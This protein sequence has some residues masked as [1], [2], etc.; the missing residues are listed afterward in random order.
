[1]WR[2]P[3][4]ARY[5]P[6][7]AIEV[8]DVAEGLAPDNDDVLGAL[9]RAHRLAGHAAL[10]ITYLERAVSIA[11]TR[12]RRLSL[13]RARLSHQHHVETRWSN[14]QFSGATPDSRSGDLI[15]NLRLTDRWRVLAR[16]QVQRKFA[17]SEERGGGGVEWRW[18]LAT[19]LRAQAL[20]GP[21]NTVMPE[22]DYLGEVE[23]TY[24]AATWTASV[25]YFDFR[26]ASTTVFSPAVAWVPEGPLS[27]ALRYAVSLT[28]T[29]TA[30][31]V[32]TGHSA[33]LRGAYRVYSWLSIQAGYAAGV[34]DFENVSIDRIGIFRA[35]T[36][37]G[38]LRIYLPTMTAVVA[39]YEHQWQRRNRNLGRVTVSLLQNF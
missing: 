10:A 4:L 21:D 13:E 36:A 6:A 5:E 31:S 37:S 1:M 29:P 11:P 28:D 18:K 17:T 26:G 16:G 9:G 35:N 20:V 30:A 12:Q 19:I 38:G 14:E 2:P 25:R 24:R 3:P 34:E 15:V 7:D 33:H 32:K 8:L 23:H 27:L 39:Q 22:G